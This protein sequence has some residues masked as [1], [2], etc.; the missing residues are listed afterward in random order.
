MITSF[1]PLI[2]KLQNDQQ[3]QAGGLTSYYFKTK[4]HVYLF[5][6]ISGHLIKQCDTHQIC[7]HNEEQNRMPCQ[8]QSL[9]SS[10][11]TEYKKNN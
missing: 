1:F 3:N 10:V 6:Y 7:H 8:L 11:K 5:P 4:K 9:P 2:S